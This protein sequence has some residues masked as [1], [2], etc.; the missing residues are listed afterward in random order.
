MN[1]GAFGKQ[2]A[3]S[4]EESFKNAYVFPPLSSPFRPSDHAF[5]SSHVA[6]TGITPI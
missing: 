6:V 1:S 5:P 3:I 2:K 4:S